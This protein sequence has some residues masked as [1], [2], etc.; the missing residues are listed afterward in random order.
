MRRFSRKRWPFYRRKV[1]S[2]DEDTEPMFQHSKHAHQWLVRRP[3]LET[4]YSSWH[5]HTRR[6]CNNGPKLLHDRFIFA[7]RRADGETEPFGLIRA[8][9]LCRVILP[10]A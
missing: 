2:N 3:C 9:Y 6:W 5:D 7:R 8:A 1:F 4:V 10:P